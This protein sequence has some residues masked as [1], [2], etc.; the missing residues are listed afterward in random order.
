MQVLDVE[1]GDD[2]VGEGLVQPGRAEEALYLGVQ[3]LAVVLWPRDPDYRV[4]WLPPA[5]P[6][7]TRGILSLS[8]RNFAEPNSNLLTKKFN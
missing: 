5:R 6:R 7:A 1:G 2:D 8:A 4:F 3:E